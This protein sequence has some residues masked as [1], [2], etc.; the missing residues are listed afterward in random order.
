MR[1]SHRLRQTSTVTKPSVIDA[2]ESVGP[3]CSRSIKG[4]KLKDIMLDTRTTRMTRLMV[5]LR[6]G[7]GAGNLEK[8]RRCRSHSPFSSL[9]L[10]RAPERIHA[11][12]LVQAPSSRQRVHHSLRGASPTC[13][14]GDFKSAL[15]SKR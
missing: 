1:H 10:Q 7:A 12:R 4:M 6:R 9:G 3:L 2:N 8:A 14:P 13:E 11:V 5:L 15:G